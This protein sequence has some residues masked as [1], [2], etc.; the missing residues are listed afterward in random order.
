MISIICSRILRVKF[1]F[2]RVKLFVVAVYGATEGEVEERGTFWND[3]GR[4]ID[5]ADNGY[6]LCVVG[7]L[8]GW[9]GG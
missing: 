8:N 4:V 6:R 9:V 7:D 1:K 2:P 3:L 5:R